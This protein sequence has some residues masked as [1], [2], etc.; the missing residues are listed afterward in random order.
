[1]SKITVQ[2]VADAKNLVYPLWKGVIYAIEEG[3]EEDRDSKSKWKH[4]RGLMLEWTKKLG[5]KYKSKEGWVPRNV[6]VKVLA[7]RDKGWGCNPE[8][9]RSRVARAESEGYL[10]RKDVKGSPI[11]KPSDKP[12]NI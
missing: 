10:T 9:A 2:D 4:Q 5:K 6:L 12:I 1:M 11:V 3:I 7:S 8:T